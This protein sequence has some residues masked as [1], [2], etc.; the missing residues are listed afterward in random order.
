M[1]VQAQEIDT[2]ID[3]GGYK[4]HFHVI[5]GKG[6]PILFESGGGDDASIWN[7]LLPNIHKKLGAT[8]ITYDRAGFGKSTI[9]TSGLIILTEVS[10]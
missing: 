1:I 10:Q 2:L 3:V 8:L 5:K 7:A 4:L 6:T 9:D